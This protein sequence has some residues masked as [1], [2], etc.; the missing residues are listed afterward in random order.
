MTATPPDDVAAMFDLAPLPASPQPARPTLEEEEAALA[1]EMASGLD[2]DGVA[3]DA[4][5]SRTALRLAVSW[6]ARM[7]LPDGSVIALTVRNV[8][9]SGVGLM[10]DEPIPADAL[11][12]FEMDVPPLSAGGAAAL[13]AGTIKTTYTVAQGG[14]VLCGGTWQEA[15]AGLDIVRGWISRLRREA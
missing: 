6:P 7:R 14:D 4:P 12:D 8:S 9:E 2:A 1:A 13:V 11:V 10:G 15:P 5:D 3:A